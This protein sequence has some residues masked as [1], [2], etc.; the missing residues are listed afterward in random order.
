MNEPTI[1]LDVRP[2]VEEFV[3]AVRRH[4]ADLPAEERDDLTEGLAADLSDLVAEQGPDVLGDP[5]AYAAE[6]RAAAGLTPRGRLRP[7]GSLTDLLDDARDRMLGVLHRPG[8]A[9]VGGFLEAVRPVWWVARAWVAVQ[10]LAM[11]NGGRPTPV[12]SVEGPAVGFLL[13]VVAAVLSVQLGRGRLWPRR[14]AW[15][16][17]TIVGLN[18]F[19]VLLTPVVLGQFPASGT[20]DV[21]DTSYPYVPGLSL[22]GTPVRN[23]YAYDRDGKPLVGVQLFDQDGQPLELDAGYVYDA[24]GADVMPFPWYAEGGRYREAY[25]VFP[26]PERTQY[27]QFEALPGA[28]HSP[29]PPRLVPPPLVAVPPVTLPSIEVGEKARE[30]AAATRRAGR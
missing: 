17:L 19:A 26:L 21:H 8:L 5:A 24:T 4:L 23:V 2:E 27:D 16:R 7:R 12:P 30:K 11:L 29:R 15:L 22:D 20:Y 28:W 10:L 14:P 6:L 25:N 9:G 3:A 1:Q 13:L 18:A